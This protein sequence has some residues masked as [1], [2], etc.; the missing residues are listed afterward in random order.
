MQL[1]SCPE[2]TEGILGRRTEKLRPTDRI[3]PGIQFRI[4]TFSKQA[5]N[6]GSLKCTC[7]L[8]RG[9]GGGL[10]ST[11]GLTLSR[12]WDVLVLTR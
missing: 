5:G 11:Q 3:R 7:N 2:S 6:V 8:W 1:N 12:L 4:G 10:M 9:G